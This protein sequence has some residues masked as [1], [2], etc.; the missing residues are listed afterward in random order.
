MIRPL[1][2][3]LLLCLAAA[4]TPAR[5]IQK[6]THNLLSSPA[7]SPAHIGIAIYD[8]A[9]GK[10]I[11]QHQADKFFVPASNV[12]ILST[13]AALRLLRDSVPLFRYDILND[14][15]IRISPLGD[16]T[17]LHADFPTQPG[18]QLLKQFDTVQ[19]CRTPFTTPL[20][21]GWAWDDYLYAYSTPRSPLP[22]YGNVVVNY[23]EN[24]ILRTVPSAFGQ[25]VVRDGTIDSGITVD[26]PLDEN[27]FLIHP[28]TSASVTTPFTPSWE[29]ICRLL[30]DTLGAVV[31]VTTDTP[32]AQARIFYGRSLD[33]V[34]K[35]MMHRSDNFFAEQLLLQ[36]GRVLTGSFLERPMFDTLSKTLFSGLPQVPVWYDGSGLSRYNLFTPEGFVLVLDRMRKEFGI[37]RL[38]QI[39]PAG[40]RGTLRGYYT[41]EP[42]FVFAKTGTLNG[43]VALSGYLYSPTGK[44]YLFSVLVNHH[45][46][47]S[48]TIRRE[49]ERY[50]KQMRQKL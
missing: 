20:G 12:K 46:Q 13:F 45:N 30:S 50:L 44:L 38:Q 28:G 43:V 24:G 11:F 19:V 18:Y 14:R 5:K 42:D 37:E 27:T 7:L 9:A 26:K 17:F 15:V 6:V 31:Q 23:L 41:G 35:P 3:L 8:P 2:A 29:T 16:P 1:C 4:C 25:N 34:L 10:F 49:V 36:S 21:N 32:L 40:G 47:S 22:L 39:F 48:V 33:S